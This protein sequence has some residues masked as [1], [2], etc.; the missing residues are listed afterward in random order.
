MLYITACPQYRCR[1]TLAIWPRDSTC[2]YCGV[3]MLQSRQ[4]I[5]NLQ[6]REHLL[7]ACDY[8]SGRA[9]ATSTRGAPHHSTSGA[10]WPQARTGVGG[11]LDRR[12]RTSPHVR[13]TA[14]DVFDA[15]PHL[16]RPLGQ[17]RELKVHGSPTS[18]SS[19]PYGSS[20]G[21]PVSNAAAAIVLLRQP[22]R[23]PAGLPDRLFFERPP[24]HPPRPSRCKP[25]SHLG[26]FLG[27]NPA[28]P[29]GVAID[30][31]CYLSHFIFV[32]I[33]ISWVFVETPGETHRVM[34]ELEAAQ[35]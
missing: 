6:Q 29:V 28:R 5:S 22:V 8:P 1:I 33:A 3:D 21:S 27:F 16:L 23:R 10:A 34:V 19:T 12:R 31:R 2:V 25:I 35:P 32:T 18:A 26:T 14:Q 24:A 15:E 4:H 7:P 13:G 20:C 9:F 11:A 30:G 17:A